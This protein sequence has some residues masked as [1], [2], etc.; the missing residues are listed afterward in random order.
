MCKLDFKLVCLDIDGTLVNSRHEITP[1]VKAAIGAVNRRGIPVVLVSARIP[2]GMF[3]LLEELEL[4]APIICYGGALILDAGRRPL[5]SREIPVEAARTVEELTC[6]AG[7]H[8]SVYRDGDWFV[9]ERDAWADQEGAITRM[10]PEVADL[11]GLLDRWEAQGRGPHKLMAMGEPE[12]ILEMEGLAAG[13]ALAV[14]RSKPTYLEITARGTSKT[15]AIRQLQE[16]LG[17]LQEE[18]LAV[19]DNFNDLE[20]IRYAGTGVAMGNAPAEV[21]AQ[22][23]WVT[24]TNDA[25]GVA[26]ALEHFILT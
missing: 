25:D 14:Y 19:G 24:A 6:R 9:R 21:Q 8:L 16:Q 20:M 1:G 18:V 22:A 23:D 12:A 15:G 2:R 26:R 7:M 17:V 3:F 13:G 5:F 4:E 10:S 11:P